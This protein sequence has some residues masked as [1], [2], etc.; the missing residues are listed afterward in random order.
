MKPLVPSL[1]S[2]H[3]KAWAAAVL[4]GAA[5][6]VPIPATMLTE[7][8]FG[9]SKQVPEP[10]LP[11]DPTPLNELITAAERQQLAAAREPKKSVEAL[12]AISDA[13][14]NSGFAATQGDDYRT[15]ERE[16]D[17]YRKAIAENCISG[18]SST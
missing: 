9:Q 15:S 10:P 14:L 13:H 8:A 5:I 12:M 18:H 6:L 7:R 3:R 2:L 16:L 11:V 1:C 4:L 17:I